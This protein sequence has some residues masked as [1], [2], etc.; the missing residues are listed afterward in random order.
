MVY[1]QVYVLRRI[2]QIFKIVNILMGVPMH[3]YKADR[4]GTSKYSSIRIKFEDNGFLTN[5]TIPLRAVWKNKK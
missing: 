4:C 3:V 5:I 2:W 1:I